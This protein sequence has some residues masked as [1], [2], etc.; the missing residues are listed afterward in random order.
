MVPN[1]NEVKHVVTQKSFIQ[2]T[3]AGKLSPGRLQQHANLTSDEMS[4]FRSAV[5]SLQWLSGQ[6][7]PDL[8]AA[9]SLCQKGS[10]TEITDLQKVYESIRH[11]RETPEFGLRFGALPFNKN[12]VILVYTDASWAHASNLTSQYGVLVPICPPQ[13]TEKTCGAFPVGWKSGRTQRMCRST[14]A[15]ESYSADEGADRGSFVNYFLTEVFFRIPAFKG[16]M[17]LN[18]KQAT[19]A[20]SLFDCLVAENPVTSEKRSM[21]AIR[22]VQQ[23]IGPKDIHWVPTG[24]M[25]ADGLTKLDS[26]LPETLMRW[27]YA[28]WCQLREES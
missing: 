23:S 7:R 18:M 25:H 1:G 14:L 15:A 28:P 3:S 8:A 26:R 24:I 17:K 9:A 21:I 5:G 6:T 27:C 19:D 20:K 13:V 11:A 4:D 2:N 22:S 12:S 10:K 16:Q